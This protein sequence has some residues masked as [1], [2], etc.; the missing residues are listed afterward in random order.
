MPAGYRDGAET[1]LNSKRASLEKDNL[2][3]FLALVAADAKL[4]IVDPALDLSV[5]LPK[6]EEKILSQCPIYILDDASDHG[7]DKD[8]VRFFQ[9]MEKIE[10]TKKFKKILSKIPQ[11]IQKMRGRR[12]A[13]N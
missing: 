5:F 3:R 4:N 12:N 9:K 13:M 6:S 11:K 8:I 10:E 1:F 7:L 2:N